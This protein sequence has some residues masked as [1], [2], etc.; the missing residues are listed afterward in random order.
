MVVTVKIPLLGSYS[1]PVVAVN[2]PPA[3]AVIDPTPA[4]INLCLL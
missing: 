4:V 2:G 3:F 1:V